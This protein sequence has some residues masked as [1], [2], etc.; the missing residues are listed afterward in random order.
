MSTS[1]AQDAVERRHRDWG[2]G[3]HNVMGF[4]VLLKCIIALSFK[5]VSESV[6]QALVTPVHFVQYIKA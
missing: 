6:G 3:A 4:Q 5:V 2:G 1:E